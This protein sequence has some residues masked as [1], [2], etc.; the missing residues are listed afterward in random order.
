MRGIAAFPNETS[1]R[2]VEVEQPGPPS[3][4]EV[5]CRTLEL[6]ICGTDREILRF[7]QPLVPEGRDFL[8]LGHECLARVEEVGP[9]VTGLAA[10]DLVIPLVRRAAGETTLRPDMLAFGRYVERG[11]VRLDGLSVPWWK[12]RPEYLFH[13]DAEM[14]PYAVLAEP[15]TCA[16]KAV[17]EALTLQRARLG[18]AAWSDPPPRV[19][20]TGMGPIGFGALLVCHVLGWPVTVYGRGGSQSARARLAADFG[21]RYLEATPEALQLSDVER[22]GFDLVL[23]CTGAEQ[24][25]VAATAALASRGIMAWLGSQRRPQPVA[26]NLA[27][28]VRHGVLRNHLHLGVVNAAPGDFHDALADLDQVRREQPELLDR[29]ITARVAPQDALWHFEHRQPQGIKTIVQYE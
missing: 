17:N 2:F 12:D 28:M 6:G 19:L 1:P 14:A 9:D 26:L 4:G 3:A 10:G 7:A 24:V 13:V 16:E 18:P 22:D 5:L 29:L 25:M 21:G 20:V 15:I 11:I 8:I 23:E 27:R